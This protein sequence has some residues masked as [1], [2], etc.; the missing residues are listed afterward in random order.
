MHYNHVIDLNNHLKACVLEY[1]DNLD[2]VKIIYINEKDEYKKIE[3]KGGKI[4][5]PIIF[6]LTSPAAGVAVYHP[7]QG[8]M[9]ANIVKML[10]YLVL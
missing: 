3:E 7:G 8:S 9:A 1:Y 6:A 10:H 2:N 5:L 4:M